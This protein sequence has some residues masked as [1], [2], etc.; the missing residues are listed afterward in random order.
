MPKTIKGG[1]VFQMVSR[2]CAVED[3]HQHQLAPCGIFDVE[4]ATRTGV[5]PILGFRFQ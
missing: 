2:W 1:A 4:S 3:W 5:S